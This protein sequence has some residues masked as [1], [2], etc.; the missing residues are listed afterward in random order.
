MEK[1]CRD[2]GQDIDNMDDP[3]PA[4][5]AMVSAKDGGSVD[6]TICPAQT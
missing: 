3:C 1:S 6:A 2:Y 5:L 4:G